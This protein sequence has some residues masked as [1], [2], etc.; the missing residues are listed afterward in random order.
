MR[1]YALTQL[2]R[3]DEAIRDVKDIARAVLRRTEQ[4]APAAQK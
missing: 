2:D 3:H 1:A 4:G